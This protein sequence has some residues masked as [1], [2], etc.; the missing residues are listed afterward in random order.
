[1]S[2]GQGTGTLA[3]EVLKAAAPPGMADISAG[4]TIDP[5]LLFG[6]NQTITMRRENA[7]PV[8][9]HGCMLAFVFL[10]LSILLEPLHA[11]EVLST[12]PQQQFDTPDDAVHTLIEAAKN[13]DGDK[14]SAIFGPAVT[15]L[16]TGDKV[17]DKANLVGFSKAITE[18]CVPTTGSNLVVLNIGTYN[19][20]FP[21]PLVK[22]DGRWFFDTDAGLDEIIDRHI[23]R[24]ELNAIGFCRAYVTAQRQ[25]FTQGTEA[26]GQ[27][28]YALKFK[29]TP[30]QQDGLYWLPTN[31][32][33]PFESVVAEAHVQ[34]YGHS[35]TGTGPHPFHGYLFRILTAQGRAAPGGKADYL[36]DGKLIGGFALVAYPEA[37]GRS[38]IMTFIVNQEG[39]VY[40]RNLG[41]KTAKIAARMTAYNPDHHWTLVQDPGICEP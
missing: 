34:G 11:R 2:M 24:D 36:V 16:L 5:V 20:P 30:G 6:I 13:A 26:G 40:Q 21:I 4:P 29:S 33:S 22:A 41:E 8:F 18:A 3:G 19:W 39:Q 31:G 37:W 28:K 32:P 9:A 15:N 7:F 23:G 38:G 17:Q 10:N 12:K 1:M 25:Y 27:K 14:I 35:P